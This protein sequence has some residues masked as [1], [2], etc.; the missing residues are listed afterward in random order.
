MRCVQQAGTGAGPDR[1][2]RHSTSAVFLSAC[3]WK[4][5]S[6]H[7]F[8]AACS[9]YMVMYSNA[10][11]TSAISAYRSEPLTWS[12]QPADITQRARAEEGA[13]ALTY[14]NR[15]LCFLRLLLCSPAG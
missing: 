15:R 7:L 12:Q 9:L 1:A 6:H 8:A 10:N 14:P 11:R 5:S 2:S 4:A 13:V 3:L